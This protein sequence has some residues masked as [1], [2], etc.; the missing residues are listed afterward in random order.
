M[1]WR[2]DSSKRSI[3]RD[4]TIGLILVV[5]IVSSIALMTA[6][7]IS[8]KKAEA[9]LNAKADEYIVFLKKL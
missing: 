5:M 8:S 9:E 4:L 1:F 2:R 7:V 6:Y 3:S